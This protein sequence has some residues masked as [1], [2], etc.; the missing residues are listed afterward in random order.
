MRSVLARR[1]IGAG[2]AFVALG[3][4][5]RLQLVAQLCDDGPQSITRLTDATTVSRQAITKHLHVLQRAGLVRGSRVGREVIWQI[6]PGKIEDVTRC[7]ELISA[8]W[9]R[10]IDRL[11]ALV[12]E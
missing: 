11:R 12:E 8:Q 2:P 6:Q 9:D 3:D 5:M 7:L 10:A 1:L 4:P